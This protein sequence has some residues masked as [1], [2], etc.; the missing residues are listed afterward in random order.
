MIRFFY[1]CE[2]VDFF[3]TKA[4]SNLYKSGLSSFNHF[5]SDFRFTVFIGVKPRKMGRIYILGRSDPCDPG[6]NHVPQAVAD[7]K[8]KQRGK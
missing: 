8:N 2:V 1:L 3:L 7:C 6:L 5:L 4:S